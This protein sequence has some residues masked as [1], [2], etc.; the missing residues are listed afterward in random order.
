[1]DNSK[2]RV[3]QQTVEVTLR[4]PPG[5][6][7]KVEIN[8]KL[9]MSLSH[10]LAEFMTVSK[11]QPAKFY[12]IVKFYLSER[13][14]LYRAIKS[15]HKGMMGVIEASMN[16]TIV[17]LMT[18]ALNNQMENVMGGG[19]FQADEELQGCIKELRD[20]LKSKERMLDFD[21]FCSKRF[22]VH[23]ME[24]SVFGTDEGNIAVD[25]HLEAKS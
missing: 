14:G 8:D 3:A 9:H 5:D 20:G 17:S 19:D 4:I 16:A 15:T 12:I 18:L 1:M 6:F 23:A 24:A 7:R 2:D 11:G 21:K 13:K 10:D 25:S 22:D